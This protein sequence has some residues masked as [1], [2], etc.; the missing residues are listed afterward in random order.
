MNQRINELINTPRMFYLSIFPQNSVEGLYS[1]IKDYITESTEM[2]EIGSFSGV[3]SELFA[4]HCKKIHC[5][6]FWSEYWEIDASKL[7]FAEEQFDSLLPRYSN[8]TKIKQSSE[9]A[10]LLFEDKSLDF[11]YIDAA[12]DY[13]NV[14]KDILL[15]LPKVK[16]GGYIAGHDIVLPG[17]AAAVGEIFGISYKKYDDSSWVAS[18]I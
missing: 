18:V 16:P 2:V 15:W 1:L 9:S 5:V 12:H 3:S 11:V 7:I 14:K 13:E 17:V 10:S 8:I 6:D 4:L